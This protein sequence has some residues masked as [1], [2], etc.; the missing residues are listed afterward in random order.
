M[1]EHAPRALSFP[2]MAFKL[3]QSDRRP[4]GGLP[5]WRRHRSFCGVCE[6]LRALCQGVFAR[7]VPVSKGAQAKEGDPGPS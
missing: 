3:S 4:Q 1:R 2:H 5:Y 7:E 6:A